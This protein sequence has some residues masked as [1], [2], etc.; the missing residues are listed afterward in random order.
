MLK[1]S[2]VLNVV[3]DTSLSSVELCNIG[4]NCGPVFNPIFN[5]NVTIPNDQKPDPIAPQQPKVNRFVPGKPFL[6]F[7]IKKKLTS[8]FFL[9]K[10]RITNLTYFTF[11]RHV[12][13][14]Y[15]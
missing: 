5:W 11:D 6:P 3:R 12:R 7:Q 9:L 14:F 2:S 15:V 1:K 8:H 4:L 10:E 13:Y